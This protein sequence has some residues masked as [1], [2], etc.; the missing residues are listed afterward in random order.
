MKVAYFSPL[1][2]STSG[3]ADYSALLLPALEHH[4]AVEVVRPGRTRPVADA[5]VALYHVGNDPDAHA[6]IVDALRRRPGVV[7]LHDFV[8]HHLVAGMTIGR[9]DG[10]A[11]L[12]AMEREAG[13]AGRMLGWG[14]LEGRVPPL[15]EVRPA[16]FPLVAQVLDRAT[17]VIVHSAYVAAQVREHGY[18]GPLWHV[19]HPA[20][21][22]EEVTPAA[23]EGA[24][25]FGCFGH[26]NENKRIPQLLRAFGAFR[27]THP[28]ARLLLVGAEAPGYTLRGELPDGVLREPYVEEPR[29]MSLIAACDAVAL[30]RAP[31]MGE[32]SGSAIRTLSLGKPLVV[33]DLGWFAELPDEVALK[34]PVGD[35][36]EEALLHAFERLAEPGVAARMGEAARAHVKH[37]HGL[38]RVAGLYVSA[39]EQAAGGAAVEANVLHE[40]AAAAAATGADVGSLAADLRELGLTGHDAVSDTVRPFRLGPPWLV[41]GV[42]YAVAVAV[43]LTLALRVKSPWI[44]V[45]ELVYSDTA[46]SIADGAG[47]TIRG[48]AAGYGYVYPLLLSIPYAVADRMTD[49]YDLARVLNAL[50]MCSVVV[51]VYLLARRVVRVAAALAAAA[52]AVALPAT[53]YVASLMTENVFYPLFA[54][55]VLALVAAL[56][57]PT[58]RRQVSVLALCVL[59][60]LTRAQA[61]VL[62]AAVPTAPLALAW[63]ERGRPRNLRA[64]RPLYG[65]VAFVALAVVVYELARGRSVLNVLGGYSAA[66]STSYQLWPALKWIALHVSVLALSAW[67]IPFAAAVVV[68][69]SAR[70]LDRQL[71]VLAAA[72]ASL[73][74]WLVLEVGVFASRYSFRLEERNLFYL[75]P[76]LVIALLAWIERGQPRPPRATVVAALVAVA[77]VGAIPF[78]ALLNENSQS[79]TPTLQ[80]WWYL[81]ASWTGKTTVALVASLAALALAAAFL[82]LPARFAPWLPALVGVGFVLTWL[83]LEAWPNGFPQAS[84]HFYD[85]GVAAGTSWIDGAVGTN[86]KVAVLWSGGDANRIWQDEFWNRSVRDVYGL[87]GAEL[88]GGM[89]QTDVTVQSETSKLVDAK[90]RPIDA[91]YVLTDT[92]APVVGQRVA[93][94]PAH[95][96]ALYHVTGPVRLALR[97]T[98]WYDDFW[99]GPELTW[100]REQCSGGRLRFDVRSDAGLFKGTVQ[101]V[102]ISG[103]TPAH[104]VVVHPTGAPR[105][106]TLPLQPQGGRCVVDLKITP[107]RMPA[108]FPQLHIQDTRLLGVR[109]DYFTYL[110]PR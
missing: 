26:L 45:D 41:L 16:E 35:G 68:L 31:T 74:L 87:D 53:V 23:V 92:R 84:V 8:I 101:Q 102:A 18:A 105:V 55:F 80:P 22:A 17:G 75:T 43:L 7:V 60:F 62:F 57:R 61:I 94:D 95:R 70:H 64:W 69:A 107:A 103:S 29:L 34:V 13:P 27:A 30:L 15:W 72:L 20:W 49:V 39:L 48:H 71:R 106:L 109:I 46:R 1:P 3:I 11:Y 93:G 79:D 66:G 52:L 67:V 58:L 5:D 81:G 28:E 19:P 42:L 100:T 82:W 91:R 96:L 40:V 99:T 85:A 51:P 47:F 2:P 4:V 32:T 73:G 59:L 9:N 86:A 89:P 36:E 25:L 108:N 21:P 78:A 63:I 12:A 38:E 77:L 97:I 76:L 110:P 104:T 98:G 33:S 65:L 54:W 44:M 10:H 14:V 83:P 90:G 88:E 50:L 24:P 37:E 56:D 6:W